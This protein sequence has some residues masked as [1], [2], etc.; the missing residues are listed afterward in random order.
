MKVGFV[1]TMGALHEGHLSLMRAA[2]A[3][4]SL[5]VASIFVNP[6]QFLPNEDYGRYPRP[7]ERDLELCEAVGVDIV[8]NPTAD[9]LVGD[10]LTTVAVEGVTELYEGLARPGH[11]E[12]VAT[13]VAKLFMLLR[14]NVAYFGLKDLQ[15]C[16][17]IRQMVKDLHFPVELAFSPTLREDDGLALSSRNRYLSET[18][19]RAAPK[20]YEIL[21]H[22][23]GQVQA[24][25]NS[26][27]ALT[28]GKQYLAAN[29]FVVDYLDWVS[30][31]DMRSI[32]EIGESSESALIAA[33]YLG[34]T[35]LI[36]N[37]LL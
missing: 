37:I 18:H 2:K 3:N 19:R 4:N 1:P 22:I 27:A 34:K 24:N 15:Q 36:D 35:R 12:G 14:P 17:V 28:E 30:V 25:E 11:F 32:R 6:L 8:F 16:L 5:T 33:A 26:D 7:I 21:R 20:L 29:G 31:P 13:I 10:G 9:E 23:S